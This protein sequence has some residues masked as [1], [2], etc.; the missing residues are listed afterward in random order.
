M[1]LADLL[2]QAEDG[3]PLLVLDQ[4]TDPHNVGAILRSAAAFDALGIVTQDRHAP[5]E[6]G[7]LAKAA[8]GALETVPWAG[9][10]TSPARST[11]WPKPASGASAWPARRR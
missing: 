4:V 3:R 7:A 2:D 9:S 6:S 1:L 5:P 11:K 10:S 8:S